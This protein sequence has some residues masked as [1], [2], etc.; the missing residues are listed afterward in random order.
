MSLHVR[1]A[2]RV[3]DTRGRGNGHQGGCQAGEV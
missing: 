2:R 3:G 1:Q